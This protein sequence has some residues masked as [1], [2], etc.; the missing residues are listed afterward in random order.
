[1]SAGAQ[2]PVKCTALTHRCVRALL[3]QYAFNTTLQRR[4]IIY[5]MPPRI[6]VKSLKLFAT[7]IPVGV[8][9]LNYIVYLY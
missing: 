4:G 1:M 8:L 3:L 9:L 6:P 7:G 2:D 5:H